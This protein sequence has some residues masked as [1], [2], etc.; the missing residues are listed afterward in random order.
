[1]RERKYRFWD[2]FNEVFTYSENHSLSKFFELYEAT[3]EGENNPILEDCTGLKD[4]TRKEIYEG[5]IIEADI[6]MMDRSRG[7]QNRVVSF[8]NG[9][10]EL[11]TTK[12]S[13]VTDPPFH[14]QP[15]IIG[16]IHQNKDLI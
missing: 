13:I 15:E 11:G 9:C 14:F 4:K 7:K 8:I 1:M 6:N 2:S 3:K 16:N 12:L 10:F 5:D